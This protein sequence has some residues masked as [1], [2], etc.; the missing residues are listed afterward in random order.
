MGEVCPPANL[1]EADAAEQELR[2]LE[3]A[4]TYNSALAA[5]KELDA[6]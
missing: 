1:A 2:W 4:S 6:E 5:G 3:N